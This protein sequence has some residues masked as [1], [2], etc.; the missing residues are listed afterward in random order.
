MAVVHFID[1]HESALSLDRGVLGRRVGEAPEERT[2]QERD[3]RFPEMVL[4]VFIFEIYPG[5][6]VPSV[7]L[8]V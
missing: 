1:V 3:Q 8:I 2:D 4:S 6:I 5:E 7:G